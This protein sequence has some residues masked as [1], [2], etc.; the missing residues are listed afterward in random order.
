[1]NIADAKQQVKQTVEAY[2]TKDDAGMYRI[3]VAH[4]RPIFLLGAPGIGKTAIMAQVADELG[5][6][7]VSYSMTH[8]TRQ[9]ALGLPV[10]VRKEYGGRDVDV[11]EYT[12]SEPKRLMKRAVARRAV[13]SVTKTSC[14][15]SAPNA[16]SM[17]ENALSIAAEAWSTSG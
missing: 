4:Q 16:W 10:V 6:G 11:S 12:M 1:M 7:L 2:L 9:S 3:S 14:S 13:S 15:R 5:I 8:H 17:K